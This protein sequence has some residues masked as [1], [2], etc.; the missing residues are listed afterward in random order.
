MAI[1]FVFGYQF[2]RAFKHLGKLVGQRHSL[3]KQVVAGRKIHKKVHITVSTFFAPGH[4]AKH[5]NSASPV[6]AAQCVY[7]SRFACNSSSSIMIA[8]KVSWL[9]K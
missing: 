6:P 3:G 1:Q 4:G 2:N 8:F 5:T 7:G 9:G